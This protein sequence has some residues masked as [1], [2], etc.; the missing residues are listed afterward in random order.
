L[1]GRSELAKAALPPGSSRLWATYPPP[2][3]EAPQAALGS[4]PEAASRPRG[5]LRVAQHFAA[6]GATFA[7][8]LAAKKRAEEAEAGKRRKN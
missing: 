4:P 8:G 2:S 5:R 1:A 3:R 7:Q 6:A